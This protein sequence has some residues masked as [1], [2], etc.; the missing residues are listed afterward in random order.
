MYLLHV[1]QFSEGPL[2]NCSMLMKFY[3]MS[4]S[5]ERTT[6]CSTVQV[7]VQ[8]LVKHCYMF[9]AMLK[10]STGPQLNCYRVNRTLV[11]SHGVCVVYPLGRPIH[12]AHSAL[13]QMSQN[14]IRRCPIVLF[15]CHRLYLSSSLCS[16]LLNV[17][18]AQ[19]QK[20]CAWR[21]RLACKASV[22][23]CTYTHLVQHCSALTC[24]A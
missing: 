2:L 7:L 24:C 9:T 10:Y 5:C 14:Y 16:L 19:S 17:R 6:I 15:I 23:T 22:Y 20:H 21:L 12:N 13:L 3:Q 18:D 1:E 11:S 4:T 8:N